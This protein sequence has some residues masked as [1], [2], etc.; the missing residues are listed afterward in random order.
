MKTY[1][2]PKSFVLFFILGLLFAINATAQQIRHL[3]SKDGLTT[4][5]VVI[6]VK[7]RLGY[8]WIGTNQGLSRYSG[9]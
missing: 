5:N 3:N 7:D 8:L 9:V 6:F 2:V 1:C 4:G